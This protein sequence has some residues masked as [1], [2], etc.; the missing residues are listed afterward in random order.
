MK[1]IDRRQDIQETLDSEILQY[2]MTTRIRQSLELSEIL[3]ATAAEIRSFLGSDRVMVYRFHADGSGEV[4]AESIYENRLPS[5]LGLNFPA[6]DIPPAARERFIREK[7]RSIVDIT[8]QQII[9]SPLSVH[10]GAFCPRS[11]QQNIYSSDSPLKKGGGG[12]ISLDSLSHSNPV[13]ASD[14]PPNPDGVQKG[15]D[16]YTSQLET[17]LKSTPIY[18]SL[19][20]CHASYLKAM[21]VT[22]SLVVPIL[23]GVDL[24]NQGDNSC[25]ELWGLLVSHNVTP[26]HFSEQQL[27]VIQQVA[28]QVA[29]A[30]AQS[31][32][33]TQAREQQ[34]QQTTINQ[35]ATLLHAQPSIELQAALEA[36]VKALAGIGGRLY[37][38]PNRCLVAE[39]TKSANNILLT[40]GEQP[41]DFEDR[42][43]S[44]FIG[45]KELM[46]WPDNQDRIPVPQAIRDRCQSTKISG[47]LILPLQYRQQLFGYLSI[48]RPGMETERLWA[49]K[50]NTQVQQ[51]MPRQSF[52]AWREV[53]RDHVPQWQPVEIEMAIEIAHH[54]SMA[55]AQ[56]LLYKQ[57]NSLNVNLE[58]QV[59]QR[60][61]QLQKS[62]DYSKVLGK[63][64][65]QIRSTLDI[66]TILQTIVREVRSLLKSDRVV[67][68]H[69]SPGG[70]GVVIVEDIRGDWPSALGI[71]GP[72][73]CFPEKYRRL[74]L[75]GRVR[76]INDIAQENLSDCHQ[77]FLEQLQVQASLVVP[78][79]NQTGLWGLM[80]VHECSAPRVW[81]GSE[82]EFLQQLASQAAIAIQQAELYQQTKQ[83]AAD[84]LDKAAQLETALTELKNTQTQLIQGEKMSALGE[85]IAGVAHEI[86][87]PM[88]FIYG[89]LVHVYEYTQDIIDLVNLYQRIYTNTDPQIDQKITEIDLDFVLEDLPQML[90]S[91]KVGAERIREIVMSLKNFSRIDQNQMKP[92]DI[93]DGIDSTLMILHHRLKP[94]NNRP[95]IL[96]KKHYGKL[97]NVTCYAGQ[98]N[99]VFMNVISNAIDALEDYN[100]HRTRNE[101]KKNPSCITIRTEVSRVYA[102]K[103]PT[104]QHEKSWI[105]IHIADNGQG[106]PEEVRSHI[107][108]AFFTTKEIG[109]GTGMGLSI[110]HQ[111]VVEKHGGLFNCL[112][113]PGK[114][115]EFIIELPVN[116]NKG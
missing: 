30:I 82:I 85:L 102:T 57:V 49:G 27:T 78:I 20:P 86:N 65:D 80:I 64:L 50:F 55:I 113:Q 44:K 53:K 100:L 4:I 93:H 91:M 45:D 107:F 104:S 95:E 109:K 33:L 46:V 17:S 103:Q 10:H 74:Y 84:A 66:D 88:N 61:T 62:L 42:E 72:G 3:K 112:S 40:Y 52:E 71:R 73:E 8:Q 31:T 87:N 22:S 7:V 59:Q 11:N 34:K 43:L 54:F 41:T 16:R 79:V 70:E 110:S 48:F 97:P 5:M 68:Y 6:D 81:Q 63:I 38:T 36:T 92:V 83:A 15:G 32:L 67:M 115:T 58:Q 9:F 2:R 25:E 12:G 94:K 108:E 98:L 24:L 116:R 89:N 13:I 105:K 75:Q 90:S 18:R 56:Y 47:L 114:G 23:L 35:I 21:G 77:Q 26:Y 14:P 101:M 39:E 28:D 60:T 29:I 106:M 19:D 1:D 96:I 76:K 69:F 111:I 51:L 99:Q 37:I